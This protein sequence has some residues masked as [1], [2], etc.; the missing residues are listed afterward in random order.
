MEN[1]AQAGLSAR[2]SRHRGLGTVPLV[3]RGVAIARHPDVALVEMA[4][5]GAGFG[6]FIFFLLN[7]YLASII[8]Y[9]YY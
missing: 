1:R 6:D 3:Q 8:L 7:N 9:S 2:L 5:L 4:A